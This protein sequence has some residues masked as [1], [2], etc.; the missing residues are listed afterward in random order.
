[1][2]KRNKRHGEEINFWQSSSDLMTALLL[3]LLLIMIL[4]LLYMLYTPATIEGDITNGYTDTTETG[5]TEE[6]SEGNSWD[7]IGESEN[8]GAGEGIT[9]VITIE[10]GGGG[11]NGDEEGDRPGEDEGIKSAVYVEVVDE[12]TK[13]RIRISDITFELYEK[14][15]AM[16][17]LNT[18]Y[19]EKISYRQYATRRDGSYYLPEKVYQGNY[20]LR[21]LTAPEGYDIAP[22]T[23]FTVD[24]LYDWPDPLLVQVEM[25]PSRNIIRVQMEDAGSGEAVGGAAFDVVAA[26]AV[27]TKDGTVRYEKGSVVDTIRLDDTGYGESIELYLGKYSLKQTEIPEYYASVAAAIPVT[28]KK[29]TEAE[30]AGPRPGKVGAE[31]AGAVVTMAQVSKTGIVLHLTDELYPDMPI[32]GAVYEITENR[33]GEVQTL[34]TDT[35]GKITLTDLEKGTEYEVRQLSST[36]DYAAAVQ[37]DRIAVDARGRID[38]KT[39]KTAELTNRMLRVSV[40]AVDQIWGTP[41]EGRELALY[42]SGGRLVE[43]WSSAV[44]A[45]MFTALKAGNYYILS[46]KG[47]NRRFDFTVQDTAGVQEIHIAVVTLPGAAVLA[48]AIAAGAAALFLLIWLLRRFA[49]AIRR[50]RARRGKKSAETVQHGAETSETEK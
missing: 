23:E 38:G 16:E 35:A 20:Y 7:Q 33:T 48:A 37:P 30:A 22:N 42:E 36:G 26:E 8:D 21:D 46:G 50:G 41:I 3:I 11:G 45:R 44:S 40:S 39:T 49:A 27:T 19:P 12:E 10:S 17:I 4:L 32:A 25:S 18:Y 31:A 15:G 28:V 2:K 9:N 29:K 43:Q 34:T 13:R 1:M 5:A 14:N 47:Q 6:K 24:Q